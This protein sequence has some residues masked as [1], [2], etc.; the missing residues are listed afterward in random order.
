MGSRPL[1][2]GT[3][4][5]VGVVHAKGLED[6]ASDVVLEVVAGGCF[7]DLA[8]DEVAEIR[9]SSGGGWIEP[10]T[11]MLLDQVLHERRAV[12]VISKGS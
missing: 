1:G 11:T 8:E 4:A 6:P 2:V 10:Q 7:D 12:R 5:E 3:R 9:M